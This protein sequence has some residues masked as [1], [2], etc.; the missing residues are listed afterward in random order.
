MSRISPKSPSGYS[1]Y[2]QLLYKLQTKRF[3]HPIIPTQIWGRQPR[4]LWRF[5]RFFRTLERKSSPIPPVLRA[6]VTVKVSQINHCAFCVDFNAMRV[7]KHEGASAKLDGLGD[8]EACEAFDDAEKAALAYAEAVTRSDIEVDDSLFDRL[9]AHY[10]DDAIVELTA[11]IAFQN[12][13]SKFNA[14]L[15]L[16][17][18]GFCKIQNILEESDGF[19]VQGS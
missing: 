13:S 12:L 14:A 3:G 15:D 7:L 16:P 10:D 8:T 17:S 5:M 11:L 2:L 1:W 18:Q 19:P 6:L 4:L 9:R